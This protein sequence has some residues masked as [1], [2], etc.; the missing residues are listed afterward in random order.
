MFCTIT[1]QFLIVANGSNLPQKRGRHIGARF[2]RD[3]LANPRQC[4]RIIGCAIGTW[5]T[6]AIPKETYEVPKFI[7]LSYNYDL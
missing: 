7:L 5:F 6:N 4:T 2:F 3:D 1:F